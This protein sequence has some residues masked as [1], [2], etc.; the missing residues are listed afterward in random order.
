MLATCFMFEGNVVVLTSQAGDDDVEDSDNAV[1][2]GHDNAANAVDD[3]HQD[4]ADGSEDGFNLR[5]NQ[6]QLFCCCVPIAEP[7]HGLA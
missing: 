4:G 6:C 1:D 7:R 5:N 2:N 3:R